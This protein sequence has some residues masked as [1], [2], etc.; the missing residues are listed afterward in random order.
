MRC[1]YVDFGHCESTSPPFVLYIK[2]L[3]VHS[4]AICGATFTAA[5]FEFWDQPA[6]IVLPL[7][8]EIYS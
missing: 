4:L 1:I 6:P 3:N 5:E 8:R 2:N 7:V